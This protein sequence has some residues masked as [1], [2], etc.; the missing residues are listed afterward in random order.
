M[1]A[2]LNEVTF[3]FSDLNQAPVHISL[4]TGILTHSALTEL[5]GQEGV[6]GTHRVTEA[7]FDGNLLPQILLPSFLS[8]LFYGLQISEKVQELCTFSL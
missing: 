2:T 5:G 7:P 3:A 1:K 8:Q 6:V 4:D